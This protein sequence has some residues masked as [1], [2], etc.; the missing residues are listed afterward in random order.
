MATARSALLA[1]TE[2]RVLHCI[3]RCV[4]RSFLCGRDSYTGASYEHRRGWIRERL[5]QLSEVFSVEI[6]S[7]A[8]MSNHL[9]VVVRT[10][11]D[12]VPSW[13]DEQVA[14]R[15]LQ[16]FPGKRILA[17][18]SEPPTAL[19]IQTLCLDRERLAKVRIRLADISWFMR[20]L[21]EPIARRANQ[22][23]Q[24]TGRFWEGR[25]KCQ[26]LDD[27]GGVL[28]CMANVSLDDYLELLDWTGRQIRSDK[29]GHIA[30]ELRPVL[31]RLD[32]DVEAWVTNVEAY[33]GLFHRVV[34]KIHRLGE[35]ARATGRSWLQGQRGARQLY[36]DTGVT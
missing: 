10:L 36:A 21:N 2:S 16:I 20:S 28:S 1:P 25:F 24:C 14:R 7:Y 22:E 33:S 19:E 17:R 12:T 29:R 18:R 8:I 23:D 15:W 27:E 4:R 3:S 5:H 26:N 6:Y 13:T 35:I 32:L 30:P 9:H 11:P 31:E 34:G